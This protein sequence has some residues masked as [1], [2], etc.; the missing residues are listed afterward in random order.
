[1]QSNI[2]VKKLGK[3]GTEASDNSSL[4]V[5]QIFKHG[6]ATGVLDQSIAKTC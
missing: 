5:N 4:D 3:Q 2:Y 1:M 6:C